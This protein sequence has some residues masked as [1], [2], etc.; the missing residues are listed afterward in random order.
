MFDLDKWQEILETINRNRLR[1]FLTSFSVGWGIFMLIIL[2]GAGNGI[3]NGVRNMFADDALNTIWVW[4]QQTSM[5]Y[6]GLKPGRSIKLTNEDYDEVEREFPEVEN[7]TSRKY[8]NSNTQITYKDK[9]GNF[10]ILG[11]HPG[12]RVVEAMRILEG[13][14]VNQ[15]D[16]DEAR[17]VA[18]LGLDMKVELFGDQD[19]IGQYIDINGIP[20]KVIGYYSDQGGDRDVRRAWIPLT[21]HQRVFGG[22]NRIAAISMTT[23]PGTSVEESTVIVE[24]L[25]SQMSKRHRFAPEDVRAMNIN[26]KAEEMQKFTDLFDYIALFIWIIGVGTIMAGIVGVSNIM[27]ILVKERTKEIGIRKAMGATPYSIVSLIMQESI[28]IT[29]V[30][31]YIGLVL[32]VVVLESLT[33]VTKDL[34]FF[35]QPEVNLNVAIGATAL[36][37][38]SGALAGLIPAVRAANI[39]PVIALR[40]D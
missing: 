9:T 11:T 26:S 3:E 23:K 14:F 15:M 40:E 27:L 16:L 21:T 4:P 24:R 30:A 31:G 7:L 33:G 37:V 25:R 8:L 12:Q 34:P 2:L 19:P 29:T 38:V 20:F 10:A 13:R 32:G 6:D 17:K 28:V 35:T 36:L 18:C 5:A 22:A 39:Q 1:T